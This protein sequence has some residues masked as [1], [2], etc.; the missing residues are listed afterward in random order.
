MIEE[1]SDAHLIQSE[2]VARGPIASVVPLEPKFSPNGSKLTYLY[3]DSTGARQVYSLD[4][5]PDE[6]REQ[7]GEMYSSTLMFDASNGSEELSAQEKLR[8]ER[9]RLFTSGVT[10]Y[11]WDY[12][13]SAKSKDAASRMMIPMNGQILMF[14][15]ASENLGNGDKSSSTGNLFVLYDGSH[16]DAVDPQLSPNGD[17]V[18]MVI[19]NDLYLLKDIRNCPSV[20]GTLIRLTDKGQE[21]GITCGLADYIAQVIS[22]ILL[23]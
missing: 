2:D 17:H 13:P 21:E 4:L 19:N 5:F 12:S 11:Q 15:G 8:R 7:E 14:E 1:M 23:S 16:G 10:S 20:P 3:P 6:L 9:M 18:A 22:A